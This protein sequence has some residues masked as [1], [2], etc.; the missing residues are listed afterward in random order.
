MGM[1]NLA[2]A[3]EIRRRIHR[4]YRGYR[5]KLIAIMSLF[6]LRKK[7]LELYLI[8][9]KEQLKIKEMCK[10]LDLSERVVRRYIKE[11]LDRKFI[12]RR[13]VEG[14]RL[15]YKYMSVSPA[16]VWKNIKTEVK[17]NISF[18]DDNLASQLKENNHPGTLHKQKN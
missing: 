13:V 3:D 9:L 5:S 17:R 7:E 18:I 8:L 1:G 14:K 15:A 4:K 2:D 10:R 11:M 6:G 12:E 16:D